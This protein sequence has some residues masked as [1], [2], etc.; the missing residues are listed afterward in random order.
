MTALS[1]VPVF[2][3]STASA[4]SRTR[5]L[6]PYLRRHPARRNEFAAEGDSRINAL[7]PLVVT[8][9]IAAEKRYS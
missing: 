8:L 6:Y 7:R 3:L 5:R 4:K 9:P 2:R 1:Q